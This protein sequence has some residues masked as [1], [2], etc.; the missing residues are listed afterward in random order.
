MKNAIILHGTAG[1]S[2]G[3]WFPWLKAEL[4]KKGWKVWVP[5]LPGSEAPNIKRYNQFLLS[6]GY[7]FDEETI[8]IG[9]SSGS[10]AILG[11]LQVLPEGTF[12]KEAILVGSFIDN[13]GRADLQ[14]LFEEPFDFETIRTRAKKF[15][16]IHSNDDPYCPLSGARKLSEM[17]GSELIVKESQK[18]FSVG[19][20]GEQYKEFPFILEVL[21]EA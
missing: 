13:L 17:L 2:K 10:V 4:E 18:H 19:T 8:L 6:S 15:V 12:I 3:N 11:L 9:H 1:S 21:N 7:A 5:D 14:G 16:L 20:A